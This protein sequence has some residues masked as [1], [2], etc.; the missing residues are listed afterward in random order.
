MKD[1]DRLDV[2]LGRIQAVVDGH[3]GHYKEL[4]G[5]SDFGQY[6]E[7]TTTREDEEILTEPILA[8]LL[9]GLLGFPKDGYFA[10]FGRSGLKPDFTPMDQIAHPFVLDAKSSS[11]SLNDHESQIRSYI[12]QRQL[13]YGVLFNLHEFRV[14]RRGSKGHDPDRTVHLGLLWRAARGEAL[15]APAEGKALE[16][17]I[18]T[19]EF[20]EMALDEKIELIREAEPWAQ[21]EARDE[22]SVDIDFLVQRLRN[23]SA[24]LVEDV[25]VQQDELLAQLE[26]SPGREQALLRELEV[27]A[28]DLAPGT[29]IANLPTSA[30]DYMSDTGLPHRVWH[31]YTLRAAQLALARIVLYRSWEDSGFVDSFL[32]DGGFGG[33]YERLDRSLRDVIDSAFAAGGQRYHWLFGGDNNYDWYRPDDETLVEILY[34]MTPFPL[35]KLDADVLGGLYESYVDEIDRDRLGQFY[36]PRS[37][38]KFMLDRAGFKGPEGV[39]KLAGDR[40][41]P[42][43]IYDFAT[44][45]G[46]F[47]VEAS[48][49]IIDQGGISED[50]VT[51]LQEALKAIV[52]GFHGTEISPFPYYLTEI[53]L[54][55]QVSR[56]LGMLRSAGKP[57]ASFAL[58]VIHT[59]SLTT[60]D[61]GAA[62][63]EGLDPE[64]RGDHGELLEDERFGF[65]P[66]DAEKREA[67]R[68]IRENDAFDLVVGNPP[69]V[70]ETNNKI[71][72]DRLRSI[73]AWKADYK[74]KSDYLYYFL[75]L[76]AEKLKPGGRLC[77]IT[78]AA[79][80]NAGNADWLREQLAKTLIL[81][82]LFLFG[83]YRLFAPERVDGRRQLRAPTPT[84]ESAILIATKGTAASGHKMRVVALE[85]EAAATPTL[86]ARE[87]DRSPDRDL[88]LE[89]MASRVDGRQGR[90]GGIHALDVVQE[91]L[92]STRPWP[93]KHSS[94]DVPSRAV[95]HLQRAL[96]RTGPVERLAERW[97]IFQGIQT[98]ADAYSPRIQ[99]RLATSFPAAKRQLD[100]EGAKPGDPILE[101]PPG[102]ESRPEWAANPGLLAR[103]IE[104]HAILWGALDED[105]Y[106]SLVWINRTDPVSRD[107]QSALEPWRPVL[108]NRAD[109]LDNPDRRW[110]ETHRARNKEEL[111]KPKVIALY[112]TDRG[113]FAVDETGKWQPSIK[114]TI[115]T[116]REEG[117]SVAYLC[118]LLNSELLDVWYAV[119]GKTPWHVRR[120]YEPKPMNEMPYRHVEGQ[121]ATDNA[122]T[123]ALADALGEGDAERAAALTDGIAARVRSDPKDARKAK[124]ALESLVRAVVANRQ[125]L[126]AYRDRFPDLARIV[127]DAW[128]QG[129]VEPDPAGFVASLP[130]D[131]TVSARID[132]QLTIRIETDGSLGKPKPEDGSLKFTH[133]RKLTAE[134]EGPAERLDLLA[135]LM[136]ARAKVQPT[137]LLAEQLPRD[138]DVFRTRIEDDRQE[139]DHLLGQGRDLVEMVERLVCALYEIPEKLTE[140]IIEHAVVRSV[141]RNT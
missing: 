48:R 140:E 104:P 136:S 93:I 99:K 131:A 60:R 90:R 86:G 106:T 83:S 27:L 67:F 134:V 119:R 76:A 21:R 62:S 128:S 24:Q 34:A 54:L 105:N 66:P 97:H 139:V 30:A 78:P 77:V 32:Y 65:V 103:S 68:R 15:L 101:L 114:T 118:G 117:L 95:A 100:E 4:T 82:E 26:L 132:P 75:A 72:F 64:A 47:L 38:V 8:E 19:F 127:K 55:L 133:S 39:F 116:P 113:R 108:A 123:D 107:V 129:P 138:L 33:A 20:R 137:T 69:Y 35:G 36:T 141:G 125:A 124:A 37:V 110:F 61:I 126:L 91:D 22:A 79:W 59:D 49:R 2:A 74:G 13:G 50:D 11:Q 42:R 17:F 111:L 53:N 46:G 63:I 9:E 16:R 85:D 102:Y 14:Y 115:A 3:R 29:D 96:D 109:F 87:D 122:Q 94:K 18:K 73:P 1:D 70:F 57:P 112:R 51:G 12:D 40:R 5:A 25:T 98:G 135:E 58:G 56:L 71:L 10:Q 81:D 31:Q 45:S 28:L 88:L 120:N 44:G 43:Q 121:S 84:I 52:N 23:L 7:S 89:E 41:E 80:M 92:V 6:L 130:T